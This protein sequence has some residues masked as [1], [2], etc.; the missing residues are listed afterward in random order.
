VQRLPRI[1]SLLFSAAFV[2]TPATF[3]M[4]EPAED[5]IAPSSAQI[6]KE[7]SDINAAIKE[8]GGQWVAGVT[9]MS[10]LPPAERRARLGLAV[11]SPWETSPGQATAAPAVS[12][13]GPRLP[14]LSVTLLPAKLDWRHYNLIGGAINVKPGN[15]VTPIRNQAACGACWVFGSVGALESR[16]LITQNTPGVKLNLSEE[17]VATCDTVDSSGVACLGGLPVTSFFQGETEPA[18]G[19]YGGIPLESCDPY[20]EQKYLGL[21]RMKGSCSGSACSSFLNELDTYKISGYSWIANFWGP[22][23]GLQQTWPTVDSLKA[24]LYE[25]GPVGVS[26]EVFSDFYSY[27]SGIYS[28]RR[29][30]DVGGHFVLLIGY[31]DTHS[32]F[33]CKN[34][35]GPGWGEHGFF[36]ISYNEVGNTHGGDPW[37]SG[38]WHYGGPFLG[39]YT[40]AYTGAVP[41]VLNSSITYPAP[42]NFLSKNLL[43]K[44]VCT[45]TGTAGTDSQKYLK[46]VEVSTNGG[47]TWH[48]A[49]DTSG[50]GTWITWNYNWLLPKDGTYTIFPM[51][52]DSYTNAQGAGVTV[53]VDNTKPASA[54]TSPAEGDA[55][56]GASYVI[57]GT[58]SDNLSGVSKVE[59]STDG[60][61]TWNTATINSGSGTTSAA[62][63]YIWTLSDGAYVIMSRAT[64][65]AQ[66]VETP[67]AAIAVTALYKTGPAEPQEPQSVAYQINQAH[68]G[69]I[70][71]SSF[72]PPLKV[73][74]TA[75]L[76]SGISYP[77]IAGGKVFVTVKNP[78]AYGT[79]L[80][81]LDAATG[82]VVWGP[83]FLGGTYYWS[84]S[85]YEN[86]TLFV[87]N[88]D[89]LL[90]AYD[91]NSGQALWSTQLTGQYSFSSPPT[92]YGGIVYIGGAGSGGTVYAVN[93]SNGAVLWTASVASGDKSS[94]AVSSDGVYV[95]YACAMSYKFNPTTGSQ[96]WNFNTDCEG[97]GGK[98]PVLYNGKLYVRD[99]VK[100]DYILDSA[101]GTNEGIFQSS[102]AP[103]FS[104]NTGI[105]LESGTLRAR[106]LASDNVLWTFTGDGTLC[107]APL[108][109]NNDVYIGSS[110]GNLYAVDINTGN[111]VWTAN[112]GVAI[113]SVDEQ[114]VSQPLTGFGAGNGL[115][116]IP[117]GSALV[118]YSQ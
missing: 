60:G 55:L 40:V 74:W 28:Y 4:A 78:S 80:Y 2:L 73:R 24:A 16:T 90:R 20:K 79:N 56:N 57:T 82:S 37:Y 104:D 45:I 65:I 10:I 17:A 116:V 5:F 101:T 113:P 118:A 36:R 98:S 7:V 51:A 41:P 110:S 62:W 52:T 48:P 6:Q 63:S 14:S 18:P 19:M 66:N 84:N 69:F 81:A 100:G 53:T 86:G 112:A 39:G 105:F 58:A 94:P 34:S 8:K 106:G 115:L 64:D 44:A 95:S 97:G 3:A 96:I 75:N 42:G 27:K 26:F 114:N 46:K 1:I 111:Q 108:I 12:G 43:G 33:I 31:D 30:N 61:K 13:S 117:T 32:C 85:C 11:P 54:I 49:K 23:F 68:S 93:E 87:V 107:S 71:M 72:A 99:V 59:V 91:A 38:G 21:G 9:S 76:G 92:A 22:S 88:Y 109:V 47:T 35:W 29:G 67:A 89:G 25:Y 50:N 102:T 70:S 77:I 103:A 15:Y 83:V